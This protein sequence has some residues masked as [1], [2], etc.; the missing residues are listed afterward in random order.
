MKE[1]KDSNPLLLHSGVKNPFV[2]PGTLYHLLVVVLLYE[3]SSTF[4]ACQVILVFPLNSGVYYRIFNVHMYV[5][6]LHACIDIIYIYI[7]GSCEF[8]VFSKGLDFRTWFKPGS[9]TK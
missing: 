1:V 7:W 6:F 2:A 3:D 8:I 9:V 4:C 5:V